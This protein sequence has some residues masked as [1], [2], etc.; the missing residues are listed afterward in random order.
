M[1]KLYA[2]VCDGC[3]EVGII[4]LCWLSPCIAQHLSSPKKGVFLQL[5]GEDS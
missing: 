5:F 1:R 3:H 2:F 4:V